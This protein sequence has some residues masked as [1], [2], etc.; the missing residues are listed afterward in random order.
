MVGMFSRVLG[1][2]GTTVR[3]CMFVIQSA[4]SLKKHAYK[5]LKSC[6]SKIWCICRF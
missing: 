3:I 6:G 1:A 5:L 2:P 4:I